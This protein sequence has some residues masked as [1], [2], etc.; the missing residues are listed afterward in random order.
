MKIL[1]VCPDTGIDVL[2]AKGAAIH[3][4]EMVNAFDVAGHE[5]HLVAPRLNR[6][7]EEPATVAATVV[8]VRVD[9]DIQAVKYALDS[10]VELLNEPTSLPKDVRRLLYDARLDTALIDRFDH[11]RPDLVYVR[12]SA[13][14]TA[15]I[16]AA[17]RWRRPLVVELNAPLGDEQERYR[18][19]AL[20]PLVNAA[21][22]RL[23][24]AASLVV[25]VSD[26]LVDYVVGR[27][28][29]PSRVVVLPNGVDPVRFT[30]GP[31][32]ID[33]QRRHGLPAGPTLGFVGGLRPWHGVERL[34]EVLSQVRRTHPTAQL[35]LAGD[36]PQHDVV[37]AEAR[38]LGLEHATH[39]LGRVDHADIPDIIRSFTV[40]LAP[41]P[42]LD[43]TF[44]FSPLKAFE[45]L[46]CGVAVVASRV[47]QL[48]QVLTDRRTAMLVEPGD[49]AACAA[50]C[51]ELIGSPDLRAELGRAGR[52]LVMSGYT[53][54]AN[55]RRR[56]RPH[57]GGCP[58]TSCH[59][60]V[61]DPLHQ[62]LQIAL[63]LT[64][65]GKRFGFRVESAEVVRLK[66]AKRCMVRYETADGPML[67]KV[68]AGHRATSPF[69]LARKL[70]EAG[71]DG[72]DSI[73]VAEPVAVFEDLSM[74]V[75]RVAPGL[76]ANVMLSQGTSFDEHIGRLAAACALAVHA[77]RVE[78][79]RTHSAADELH[80][81]EHRLALLTRSR[82]ELA[83]ALALLTRAARHRV[84]RDLADRLVVTGIH[85]DYY[86]DQL[87]IDGDFVTIVDFDLY[88]WGDPAVDVGNF[89]AHLTEQA[90]RERND[91]RALG[92]SEVACVEQF[93]LGSN[94]EDRIAI[95]A[96]WW[97]SLAEH[98][99]LSAELPGREHLTI[100]LLSLCLSAS[101]S[102][103]TQ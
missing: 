23:L 9:D 10:Q 15:G 21:E 67:G 51:I 42:H 37:L 63:D 6:P 45:Y 59:T 31:P 90:L 5:V 56:A 61:G 29:D 62:P 27:G 98:V 78:P 39:L 58:M 12:A 55:A 83:S 47:G 88:C 96:Y 69:Q 20:A 71:L 13:L 81:L 91:H 99:S 74:W 3:V 93:L 80:I 60:E 85:R 92:S 66:P 101:E 89:V 38:R 36:G 82:P 22:R 14:S 34:P 70:R 26:A 48:E 103:V 7:G 46:G 86:A 76:P 72:R 44:Y 1:Y 84:R 50:A 24:T 68:R 79:R 53:W 19:G 77:A 2:G 4:R 87:V 16:A 33:V 25:C 73:A 94:R 102:K 8:R 40:A 28:V 32:S 41:Y 18:S 57:R 49:S 100:P 95:D 75:Q 52:D 43:H 64:E 11:E 17:E 35:V 54:E 65:M 30:P 97:L